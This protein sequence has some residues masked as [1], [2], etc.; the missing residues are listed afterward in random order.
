MDI[1]KAY[2]VYFS[3]TGTTERAVSAFVSGT[4]LP[5]E[6][7]D[8]TT[9]RVRHGFNRSF[10]PD[11][12]V[13]V[14]LPVYGG[15]LPINIDD[16]FF[17]LKGNTTPAVVIVVY[18]NREYDDALIELKLR[19]ENNGFKVKAAATFIGEHTLSRNIA[20]G[21][22]DA[23][24][25]TISTTFANKTIASIT[26]NESGTLHLKGNYPFKAIGY[27]PSKPGVLPLYPQIV[28]SE[29]CVQCGV[30]I[31][32]CPWEAID[33]DDCTSINFTICLRCFRCIRNCSSSAKQVIDAKFFEFIPKFEMMLNSRRREPEL[34]LPE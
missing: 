20:T 4:G 1:K 17:G 23:N 3:P 2:A 10:A 14:G 21:R 26:T 32:N 24:D 5:F 28:T 34:F 19:L 13:V 25:I 8:L 15:R 12:L 31:E 9:P 11:E 22:P 30:C 27:N 29:K 7:V 16:F 33:K 6:K 18:G